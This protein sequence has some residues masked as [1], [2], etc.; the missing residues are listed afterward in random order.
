MNS[1]QTLN[2][3]YF[4]LASG[5]ASQIYRNINH[6]CVGMCQTISESGQPVTG[7]SSWSSMVEVDSSPSGGDLASKGQG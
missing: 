7:Q 5:I 1:W 4:P 2:T 3:E 6:V